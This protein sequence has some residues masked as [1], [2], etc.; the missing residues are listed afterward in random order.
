[1]PFACAV[2]VLRPSAQ[3][4][5]C[6]ERSSPHSPQGCKNY[7]LVALDGYGQHVR[8]VDMQALWHDQ[9]QSEPHRGLSAAEVQARR[10]GIRESA[11]MSQLEPKFGIC[12]VCKSQFVIHGRTP[13]IYCSNRCKGKVATRRALDNRRL[14]LRRNEGLE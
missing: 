1:M 10:A 12:R 7:T 8:Q 5:K 13:H 14:A 4:L 9:D 3:G 6:H 11:R 2:L